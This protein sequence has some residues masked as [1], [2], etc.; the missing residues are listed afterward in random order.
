VIVLLR[1]SSFS[2]E[3]VLDLL[4]ETG[5][6]S[7]DPLGRR[8]DIAAY[9]EKLRTQAEIW[10][11]VDQGAPVG[12]IAYY[13]NDPK[14]RAA[15]LSWMGIRQEHHGKKIGTALLNHMHDDCAKKGME[16]IRL[17]VHPENRRAF[18][19]YK[20]QGYEAVDLRDGKIVMQRPVSFVSPATRIDDSG[21]FA[22]QGID[23][24]IKRDDLFPMSGGGNKARKIGYI[25]RS[26]RAGGHNAIVT[27]GG[28]QSN[29]AR[30]AAIACA[31]AGLVCH[32][33]L[34]TEEAPPEIATGNLLLMQLAGAEIE[35][36]RLA[37]LAERMDAAVAL[38]K[39]DGLDPLYVWGGGHCPEGSLAYYEA[40]KEAQAQCGSWIP[41]VVIVASGT[42]TTQAGL[43][44]GY[45]QLPTRVL[46]ISVARD[47]SRGKRVV[48]DSI[49]ELCAARQLDRP[50]RDVEFRDDWIC[51]G[52]ECT[53]GR[54]D[55][56]LQQAGRHGLILDPTY[57][58]K[59]FLGLSEL[60]ESGEIP[61]GS[62]VLFWHTGGLLNLMASGGRSCRTGPATGILK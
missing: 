17:E 49:A 40:A 19:L 14:S 44:V 45:A 36:C 2:V 28:L 18:L 32:L 11:F 24:R 20:R 58:G 6:L 29:H 59:A 50:A 42:G 9:F 51:G 21:L 7:T 46:G 41:D 56:I 53:D 30:A 33:V 39:K 23:L 38:C 22:E 47:Q 54:L 43:A 10:L 34:H 4:R 13:A 52:Y 31:E 15:Y 35:Y 25:L 8:L 27:N 62:K 37:E 5:E 16:R 3:T 12:M 1:D 60:I 48:E 57:T 55:R 26:A 61:P